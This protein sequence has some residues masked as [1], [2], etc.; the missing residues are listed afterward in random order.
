M[1]KNNVL[2]LAV[3]MM[4]ILG[5]VMVYLG[6]FHAPKVMLPPIVTGVGF[7]VIGWA[8]AVLRK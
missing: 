3:W 1:E 6:G 2:L 4:I 5:L 8:F 7:F